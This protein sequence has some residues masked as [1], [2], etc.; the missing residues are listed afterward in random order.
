MKHS[1]GLRAVAAVGLALGVAA[2]PVLNHAP[3][4][5]AA[6][7]PAVSGKIG[8]LFSDFTTSDRWKFDRSYYLAAIK[9]LDPGITVEIRDAKANQTTQQ[10]Q[11]QS[12][13]TSGVKALI[14]VP[15]DST[16]AAQI[17]NLAHQNKPRVP[18]IAYDRLINNAPV[19]AYVS[20][21][22]FAVGKQQAQYLVQHLKKGATI[23]SIAGSPTDNNAK[24]FHDG[25]MSVLKPAGFKIAYDKYTPNWDPNTA[26]AEVSSALTQNKNKVDAILVANDGMAAGVVA[27]LQGQKLLGKVY[28]TGQ[29]ATVPGLQAILEGNQSMTI[30]K[31]LRKLA[32]AAA[33]I[34]DELLKGHKVMSTTTMAN[35]AGNI[36]TILLPVVTVT[37]SNIASTVVKDGYVTKAQLCTGAAASACKSAGL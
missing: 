18:V 14:D 23:V 13:L 35:G 5:G 29:D 27:A 24:L 16:Q 12:L 2:T 20:F 26:Q 22:G 21:D 6:R 8:F 9:S 34:T 25:A 19:D 33:Q 11:A 1:T 7:Q 15:T 30:Y 32:S 4:A 37:K 10:T 17:V 36:P 31:P 3:H 28:V